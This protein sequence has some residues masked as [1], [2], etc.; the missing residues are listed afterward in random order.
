MK[1][2]SF[3]AAIFLACAITMM[4]GPGVSAQDAFSNASINGIYASSFQ[5]SVI[6]GKSLLPINGTAIVSADGDGNLKGIESFVFNG[7]ACENVVSTGTYT[8]KGDGRGTASFKFTGLTKS[9]SGS[10]SQSF[11]IAESGRVV[12]L[13]NVSPASNQISEIWR[14]QGSPPF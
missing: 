2:T 1:F 6:S 10:Y 12:V 11:V 9:C 7:T 5:G 13:V 14:Q 4:C 3:S 8:V